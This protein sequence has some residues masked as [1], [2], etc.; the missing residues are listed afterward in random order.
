MSQS[1]IKNQI[2][3]L[4]QFSPRLQSETRTIYLKQAVP[5]NSTYRYKQNIKNNSWYTFAYDDSSW[6]E[7]VVSFFEGYETNHIIYFR[8][9]FTVD[10]L[11]VYTNGVLEVTS[12]G[13]NIQIYLN[14]KYDT[15]V[16]M[17]KPG[18]YS[19]IIPLPVLKEGKN[20]IAASL[21][22][23]FGSGTLFDIRLHLVS[24]MIY[25]LLIDGTPSEDQNPPYGYPEAAFDDM[26][27]YVMEN[28][29]GAILWNYKY[30]I[31]HVVNRVVFFNKGGDCATGI[32]IAGINNGNETTLFSISGAN[33]M[34]L[35]YNT[36]DFDN[37]TPY[38]SYR[39]EFA[40]STLGKA[41]YLLATKLYYVNRIV[42]SPTKT[43]PMAEEYTE[44]FDRCPYL[45]QGWTRNTCL[46]VQ[47]KGVWTEADDT[48]LQKYPDSGRNYVDTILKLSRYPTDT[49]S[50]YYYS[51]IKKFMVEKLPVREWEITIGSYKMVEIK[52]I[53][54]TIEFYIRLNISESLGGYMK[55]EIISL[56]PS[57]NDTI[58]YYI[59]GGIEASIVNVDLYNPIHWMWIIVSVVVCCVVFV[60][61]MLVYRKRVSKE[62]KL[63][64][65]GV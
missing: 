65:V 26:A 28:F 12:G 4:S 23:N 15:I 35:Y 47:F 8:H 45:S 22:D 2:G 43:L 38:S 5:F 46:D 30:P 33:A 42:C 41:L 29:P 49:A 10:D 36:Y 60:I 39:I 31:R 32:R 59:S 58:H 11:S 17:G 19:F 16:S 21:V 3:V 51:N 14:E 34:Q 54:K 1:L 56:K 52:G 50:D 40:N 48:C 53:E 27:P 57:I 9:L 55:K 44:V 13:G 6:E 24:S 64:R 61:V 62:Y 20:L 25:D 63:K 37:E 7:G 18:Y